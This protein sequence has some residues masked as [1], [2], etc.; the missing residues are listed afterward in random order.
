MPKDLRT[1]LDQLVDGDPSA[2][3]VVKREVDPVF[4]ATALVD[5]MENDPAYPGFPGVMFTNIQG[6][7]IPLLLNLHG[8]YERL[9][10]SLDSDIHGM[11]E[12]Y[13]KRET[14]SIPPKLVE[15]SDAPVQEVVLTGDDI[16]LRK[17][18]L[19][20][21]QELDAG[22]YITSAVTICRDPESQRLNAGIFRHQLQDKDEIGIQVNPAHHTAY[23]LRSLREAGK[24]ME[25][26]LVIGHHPAMLMGAVSKLAGIG[27]EVDVMGGLLGEAMETVKCK[28]VDLEVPARAE[29]V[30]EGIIDTDPEAMR[31]EGPFG[32]YPRFYTHVG[33][34]P[35]I[36]VTAVTMRSD[37]IFVDVFNAHTE[38][39]MLGGLPRMGSI[40]RRVKDVMPSVKAINLPLSGMAR[41]HLYISMSKRV[42]GE[43]KIAACAAFTVD[44]LLKHIFI[45]DDDIDVYDEVATLWCLCTRFQADRDLTTMPNF[46]GG[47]LNPSTYGFRREEKGPMETKLIFDCTK[48]APPEKFPEVCRIP[49]DV[50]ARTHASEWIEEG[51][52][53]FSKLWNSGRS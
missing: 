31:I 24:P 35:F 17:L 37:A 39:S 19:L 15:A 33:P 4:G 12:E 14:E 8:T 36:K 5:K 28:T 22:K 38:H 2:I 21:H 49:P 46:L 52:P 44:P 34:M 50:S 18:P 43:P 30:I 51:T 27:G 29:I 7:D 45:V 16:D 32:E 10:M 3:R 26:A 1:Y 11:V 40:F 9:A 41:S 25:V 23:V 6:S 53:D 13:A 42:E 47:H 48:P 20:L